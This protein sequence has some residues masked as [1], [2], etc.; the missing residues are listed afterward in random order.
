MQNYYFGYDLCQIFQNLTSKINGLHVQVPT[1]SSKCYS[2][3]TKFLMFLCSQWFTY[4]YH[5]LHGSEICKH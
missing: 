3:I 2:H 1:K 5:G 4:M